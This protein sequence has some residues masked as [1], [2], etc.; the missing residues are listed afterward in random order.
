MGIL[1][2]AVQRDPPLIDERILAILETT[3]NR[4]ESEL[5]RRVRGKNF[6]IRVGARMTFDFTHG[7]FPGQRRPLAKPNPTPD[8]PPVDIISLLE[9][10]QRL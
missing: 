8:S 3:L 1:E 10:K 7:V 5:H 6:L 4:V 2:R 9:R